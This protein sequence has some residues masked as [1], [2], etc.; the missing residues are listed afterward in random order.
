M[1]KH[2]WS[3]SKWLFIVLFIYLALTLYFV[4][5]KG[6]I[7]PGLYMEVKFFFYASVI[8]SSFVLIY[9]VVKAERSHEMKIKEQ[10]FT[11]ESGTLREWLNKIRDTPELFP[12][13]YL[14]VDDETI[15]AASLANEFFLS[16]D[17]TV[18]RLQESK[19]TM[20]TS[21]R[22]MLYLYMTP[23]LM[24]QLWLRSRFWYPQR[25]KDVLDPMI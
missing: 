25:T 20:S 12:S 3:W 16:V 17:S 24:K 6:G 19:M 13:Q 23:P 4:V 7:D 18:A 5:W 10:I 8:L 1:Q 15:E 11:E 9:Q 2:S 22:Q 14:G 21:T